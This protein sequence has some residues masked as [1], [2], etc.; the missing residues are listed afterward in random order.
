MNQET[1]QNTQNHQ[2]T[3]KQDMGDTN[4][5]TT[6]NPLYGVKGW[7]KFFVV[8]N[9]YIAPILFVMRYILAWIGFTMMAE[10]YPNIIF[11]GIIETVVGAFLVYKAIQVARGL[12]DI[13]ERA[14]QNAKFFLK[15]VLA[16]T[17]ISVPLSFLSGLDADDLMPDVIRGLLS[18]VIGFAIWYSYFNMSQRVKATY[19]DWKDE[20]EITC[21]ECGAELELEENERNSKQFTCP[22]CNKFIDLN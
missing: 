17:I 11:V 9:L 5:S 20:L 1:E 15:L 7:L 8:V 10:K 13:K 16:W 12:R 14:V 18:G 3:H 21:P 4:T 6:S 2:S 19:P 22:S